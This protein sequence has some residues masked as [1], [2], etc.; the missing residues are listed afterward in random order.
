MATSFSF[1]YGVDHKR[2]DMCKS[3][4]ISQAIS[5]WGWCKLQLLLSQIAYGLHLQEWT[6]KI[7]RPFERFIEKCLY[8]LIIYAGV[9]IGPIG[10]P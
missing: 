9:N 4:L 6:T 2:K 5:N 1:K 8:K 10:K 3:L 7:S